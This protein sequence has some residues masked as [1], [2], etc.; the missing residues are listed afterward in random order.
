MKKLLVIVLGFIAL[1]GCN[2]ENSWDC[3]QSTGDLVQQEY[4]LDKFNKIIVWNRVKLYVSYGEE[5]K[6]VI[7]SGENLMNEVRVRVEDSILKVSDRNSCNYT[8]DYEV[9][10][11][12]VTTSVD[13]LEIR[14]S[15]GSTVEGVGPIKFKTLRLISDDREQENEFHIDGDFRFDELDV[16]NLEITAN[17]LSKFFLNG[18]VVTAHV[19][20]FDGDARVEAGDLELY[21]LYFY[22]RSTNKLIVKPLVRLN[23]TIAGIGDVISKNHPPVVNV[24]ELFTGTLIFE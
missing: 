7:E 12:F 20:L 17:G 3:F 15:S 14:N 18:R 24:E 22:H 21:N 9:T 10:K 5:Q 16:V 2:M 4:D 8:R 11:V 19:G 13:T 23:G 6:V 1:S